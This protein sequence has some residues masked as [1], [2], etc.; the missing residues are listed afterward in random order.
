[1]TKKLLLLLSVSLLSVGCDEEGLNPDEF[2]EPGFS[3]TITFAGTIP[4][5]DSI[6][7]L[8]VVAVPYFPIDTTVAE[9]ITKI[10]NQTIPY[11][12]SLSDQVAANTAIQYEMFVKPDTFKYVAVAQLFNS[13][14]PFQ[15]WRVVSIYG[16][17]AT[18][19]SPVVVIDGEM[20]KNINFSVDFY[21]LP[22]QPFKQ[23]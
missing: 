18:N 1:M 13:A 2:Q 21:N 6:D 5:R 7:D 15:D 12:G 11:S 9:L 23:P 14:N 8:R 19:P 17:S 4:P 10:L 20:K 22:P 3:G 16:N